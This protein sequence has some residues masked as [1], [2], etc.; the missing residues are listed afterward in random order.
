[1]KITKT[2]LSGLAVGCRTTET[3]G[4]RAADYRLLKNIW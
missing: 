1:M 4:S 2:M 3:A